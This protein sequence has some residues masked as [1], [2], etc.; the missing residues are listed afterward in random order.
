M[1]IGDATPF[2]EDLSVALYYDPAVMLMTLRRLAELRRELPFET[3]LSGHYAPMHGG[4]IDSYL[5]CCAAYVSP[6]EEVVPERVKASS[7]G[8]DARGSLP[9]S[10]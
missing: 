3:L 9:N 8:G 4:E 2:L 10:R 1:I 5:D 6:F 7:A